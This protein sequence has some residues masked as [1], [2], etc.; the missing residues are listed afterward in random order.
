MGRQNSNAERPRIRKPFGGTPRES[1][2]GDQDRAPFEVTVADDIADLAAQRGADLNSGDRRG[3]K[4]STDPAAICALEALG[5]A[6]M[7]RDPGP[8]GNTP[9]APRQ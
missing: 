2:R 7:P 9:P 8:D 6:I 4:E 5:D 3:S 1:S